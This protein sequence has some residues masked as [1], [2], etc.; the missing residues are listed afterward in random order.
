[1]VNF[2]K[3][4]EYKFLVVAFLLLSLLFP[5][6][7]EAIVLDDSYPRLANHFLKWEI[8]DSEVYELAKWD[9]LT[10]DMEVQLNSPKQ[11]AKIR[12]LNP[13]I[14]I[15]AYINAVELLDNVENYN[16]AFMRN[17]LSDGII[18]GWWLKNSKGQ[19]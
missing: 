13:N 3:R 12:E 19:N 11:L 6:S 7:L 9:L 8:L 5:F 10:L 1:M 16:K 17:T 2:L 14:I 15:L 18:P 4:I